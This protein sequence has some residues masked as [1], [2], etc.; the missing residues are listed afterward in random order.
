[1]NSELNSDLGSVLL[2]LDWRLQQKFTLEN[3]GWE[4]KWEDEDEE[5]QTGPSATI[6]I[7]LSAYSQ[8]LRYPSRPIVAGVIYIVCYELAWILGVRVLYVKL[9]GVF[10]LSSSTKKCRRYPVTLE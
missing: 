8:S 3:G 10:V 5:K 1:M 7:L 9:Y 6:E 4:S 2:I